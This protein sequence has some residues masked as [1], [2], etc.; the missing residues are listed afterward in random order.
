MP[1]Y[2]KGSSIKDAAIN[3]VDYSAFLSPS[4]SGKRVWVG[5]GV[6]Y[7]LFITNLAHYSSH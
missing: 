4:V 3:T 5:W 6:W 7:S 2:P 1:T